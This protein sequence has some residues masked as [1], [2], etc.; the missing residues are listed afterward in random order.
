[1]QVLSCAWE[2]QVRK[3]KGEKNKQ[4]HWHFYALFLSLLFKRT[5]TVHEPDPRGMNLDCH[6]DF[7]EK[8]K[9]CLKA[10]VK[11]V[12]PWKEERLP[13]AFFPPLITPHG[14]KTRRIWT[15]R[16][17]CLQQRNNLDFFLLLLLESYPV[18][19]NNRTGKKERVGGREKEK[20]ERRMHPKNAACVNTKKEKRRTGKWLGNYCLLYADTQSERTKIVDID[21]PRC[22]LSCFIP[23]IFDAPLIDS[24]DARKKTF[25]LSINCWTLWGDIS[26]RMLSPP[27]RFFSLSFTNLF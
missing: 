16:G 11:K 23:W 25:L 22:C 19:V 5:L 20:R 21:A 18:A 8:K 27:Q 7:Q 24:W 12:T 10:I 14:S 15:H 4:F 13:S 26:L 1:M 3:E 9:T 6:F 2:L 17:P